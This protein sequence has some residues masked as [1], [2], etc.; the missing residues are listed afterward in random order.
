MK[1]FT[2]ALKSYS[3]CGDK[4]SSQKKAGGRPEVF[5]SGLNFNNLSRRPS[6][7]LTLPPAPFNLQAL[8]GAFEEFLRE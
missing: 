3:M 4:S 7:S 8:R 1:Q 5:R 6:E 2:K